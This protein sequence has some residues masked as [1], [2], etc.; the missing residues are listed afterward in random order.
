M[1][2]IA[3]TSAVPKHIVVERRKPYRL[4]DYRFIGEGYA[5]RWRIHKRQRT[6]ARMLRKMPPIERRAMLARLLSEFAGD[7]E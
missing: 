4:H 6:W 7:L 3:V 1:A 2:V 5:D